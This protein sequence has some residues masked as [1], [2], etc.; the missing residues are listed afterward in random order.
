MTGDQSDIAGRLRSALPAGWFP[1]PSATGQASTTPVLDGVLNGL[2]WPFAYVYSLL[3]YARQ[4]ARI[5][6]STGSFLDMTSAQF[7]G[8]T[9]PR[10]TGEADAAFRARILAALF[11]AR[12]TRAAVISAVQT[13]TGAAPRVIEPMQ[14]GDCKGLGSRSAHTAGG[15]YGLEA[16]GLRYGSRT[17]IPQFVVEVAAGTTLAPVEAAIA[18]TKPAGT[19]AGVRTHS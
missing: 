13:V 17:A 2:A 12:N 16:N 4:Q 8:S 5:A 7:L 19:Y 15:G 14:A 11:P 6:T 10:H 9:L 1:L 18:A 3:A